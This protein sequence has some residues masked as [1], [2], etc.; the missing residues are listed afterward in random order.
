MC[1]LLWL[2]KQEFIKL[3]YG[4]ESGF[5]MNSY[6]PS[7]WQK[8]DNQIKIIPNKYARTNV[9]GLLNRDMDFY[10]YT[11]RATIDSNTAITFMN[12][13]IKERKHKVPTVIILDN[14]SM[15]TSI[16]FEIAADEWKEEDVYIFFLPKYAP[17]LNLIETLWRKIKY[18]WL[19]QHKIIG[20]NDFFA[21]LDYIL[22]K[23]GTE[24]FIDF[25]DQF[26]PD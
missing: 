23:I 16:E 20:S 1:G 12:L 21:A 19:K 17:H 7:A 26:L 4:D 13:F 2:E 14:A 22:S 8:K 3:Y 6:L 10:A 18:E 25:K 11:T 15:H 5:V 24:F 9:F